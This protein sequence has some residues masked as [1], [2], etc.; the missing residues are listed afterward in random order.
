MTQIALTINKY[1]EIYL[2]NRKQQETLLLHFT[3]QKSKQK[4]SSLIV[5]S[6]PGCICTLHIHW[7]CSGCRHGP[8]KAPGRKCAVTAVCAVQGAGV[9]LQ[10]AHSPRGINMQLRRRSGQ[11]V[12]ATPRHHAAAAARP[13]HPRPG[14]RLPAPRRH[15]ARGQGGQGRRGRGPRQP[16]RAVPGLQ[17][18]PSDPK[19]PGRECPLYKH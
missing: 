9:R 3:G 19:P 10:C 5:L 12:P 4:W 14:R 7:F 8:K 18:V 16:R 11:C 6:I 13:R 15:R 2:G 1:P 17:C